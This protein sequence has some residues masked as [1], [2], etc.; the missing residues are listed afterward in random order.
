MR[1]VLRDEKRPSNPIGRRGFFV[2][3]F[4]IAIC[5]ISV[6]CYCLLLFHLFKDGRNHVESRPF[7]GVFVHA[8]ADQFGHVR[9]RA[10]G[11]R[12]PQSFKGDLNPRM[13]FKR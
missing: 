11:Y 1:A 4:A 10:G 8:D 12:Y 2:S 7:A 9:T 3:C 13:E 5:K 6:F